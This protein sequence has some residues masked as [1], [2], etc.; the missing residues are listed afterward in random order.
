MNARRALLAIPAIVVGVV[1]FAWPMASIL[2]TGIVEDPG[3]IATVLTSGSTLHAVW[4]TTWQAAVSTGLT[5]VIGLPITYVISRFEFHGR[6]FVRTLVT[7]PFVL[8][9]VV[10]A[11]AFLELAGSDGVLGVDLSGTIWLVLAAHVFFNIAVVVRTVGALWSHLDPDLESAA[12]TLGA[13]PARIFRTVT[14]PLLRPAITAT[15]A[16]VFLFSFTSFG[17]VLLL[18]GPSLATIEVEIYRSAAL[19]FDLPAAAVLALVQL[20]GVTAGLVLYA[21]SQERSATSQHLL[22]AVATRRRPHGAERRLVAASSVAAIVIAG[23]PL[24]AIV[25]RTLTV[26]GGLGVGAFRAMSA[27]DPSVVDVPAAVWNSARFALVATVIALAAAIPAAVLVASRRARF[28]RWIDTLVMLPIGSSAVTLGFGFV[29]ALDAPIDLRAWWALVP[30]AHALV[31]MPFVLRATVPVIRSIAPGVRHAAATLGASPGRVWRTI[32]LP[33]L[34]P[35]AAGAAALAFMISL[36]E[37]GATLFIA[38]PEGQTMTLAIF[39]LLGRPGATNLA[40]ALGLSVVLV[41]LTA[42]TVT[43]IDRTRLPGVGGF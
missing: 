35:A 3:R 17:I 24:A 19:V 1:F 26:S 27:I 2:T 28:G 14:F 13:R 36:G 10:V 29:V 42:A 31:A 7:I 5:L 9:T 25:I 6:R 32:D 15:A 30:I 20:V 41:I 33:I 22:P 4:F 40:A 43:I 39:R 21:R 12:A 11:M 38:R 8:P 16:I 37:F 18:G 34:S 23:G